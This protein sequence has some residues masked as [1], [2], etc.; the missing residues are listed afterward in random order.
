MHFIDYLKEPRVA[1]AAQAWYS[2]WRT[3]QYLCK[4]AFPLLT[5]SLRNQ[6]H[7]SVQKR[8]NQKKRILCERYFP[9]NYGCPNFL[10]KR[11]TPLIVG[12]F[13]GR[14]SKS[15]RER[16]TKPAELLCNFYSVFIIYECVRGPQVRLLE[17][18]TVK[19]WDFLFCWFT[20]YWIYAVP[21]RTH[22]NTP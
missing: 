16:Y 1:S 6:S 9:V 15:D 12:W 7:L 4:L 20:H 5:S 21:S 18:H 19:S 17:T 11:D 22:S 14:T 2:S 3:L 10:W 13:L 8:E